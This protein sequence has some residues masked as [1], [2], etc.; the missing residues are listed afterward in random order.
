MPRDTMTAEE[1]YQTVIEL[2]VPDRVPVAP[3]IYYFAAR[4]A[5]ITMQELWFDP[6]KY[7]YAIEKCYRDLGPWDI[8]FPI[9]PT[10][11]TAYLFALPMRAKYPGI[12]L[13]P[14]ERLQLRA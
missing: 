3:M 7:S 14:D 5:G 6:T 8:Y 10:N 2:G 13:P 12:D 4:Y 9:N 1:R 11:P